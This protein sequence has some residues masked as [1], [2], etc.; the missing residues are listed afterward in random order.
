MIKIQKKIFL[1]RDG[2]MAMNKLK[3]LQLKPASAFLV[4]KVVAGIKKAQKEYNEWH[5]REI[6][7][8]YAQKDEKGGI[9]D[10]PRQPGA[11]LPVEGKEKEMND[12][13]D[14]VAEE[15]FEIDRKKLPTSILEGATL[16]SNDLEYLG[17][18]FIDP[19]QVD[20]L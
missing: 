19:G 14:K 9:K 11:F 1:T 16:S 2:A 13:L 4:N 17:P 12:L 5:K 6:V 20:D 3:T 15:H 10:D 18:I 8:V 7:E